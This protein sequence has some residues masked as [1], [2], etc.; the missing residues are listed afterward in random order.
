MTTLFLAFAPEY[1]TPVPVSPDES[2]T[3]V[4]GSSN[5]S[6]TPVITQSGSPVAPDSLTV[7]TQPAHGSASV[8]G[9]SLLY[10]PSAS[11]FGTDSFTYK[12]TV[13]GI[14]WNV[15]T[16]T[17]TVT[18]AAC[19]EIG[20]TTRAVASAYYRTRVHD[21]RLMMGEKRCLVADFSGVISKARTIV[22]VTWRCDFGYIAQMS[23]ARI[24]PGGRSAAVDVVANWI[25]DSIIRCEATLDNGEVYVQPFRVSVTGDPIFMPAV[26]GNGPT[27]L[28]AP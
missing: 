21:T 27:V 18:P 24:Q 23:R 12:A 2:I 28:T 9:V 19:D 10:T 3:C 16:V 15:G 25:G 8:D 6:V 11:Y 13:S 22:S 1:E 7:V 26:S 14:D 20:R 5:N 17:A 4:Q